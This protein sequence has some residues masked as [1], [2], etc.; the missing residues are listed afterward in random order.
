MAVG[1][2]NLDTTSFGGYWTHIG[3]SGWCL[4][5]VLMGSWFSGDATSLRDVGIDIDGTGITASLEGGY[6]VALLQSRTLEPQAQLI[7]QHLSPE[8]SDAFSDVGFDT[9]DG[10][11]GRLGFRLQGKY[12]VR[13]QPYVKAN[14]WHDFS[15]TDA[16]C[17]LR[18]R[19]N[20]QPK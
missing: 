12:V 14:F 20:Y 17:P 9:D 6:P 7:G 3:P 2:L 5:G 10:V 1:S 11:T 19:C 15:G 16:D 8:Q 4:D 18:S 13:F